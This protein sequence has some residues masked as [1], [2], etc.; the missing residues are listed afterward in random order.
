MLSSGCNNFFNYVW[1]EPNKYVCK[2]LGNFAKTIF[3]FI[4]AAFSEANVSHLCYKYLGSNRKEWRRN[5]SDF[6]IEKHRAVIEKSPSWHPNL[7]VLKCIGSELKND[8]GFWKRVLMINTKAASIISSSMWTEEFVLRLISDYES[9][10]RVSGITD[11]DPYSIGFREILY[12]IPKRLFDKEQIVLALANTRRYD[13]L[14]FM[15]DRLRSNKEFA[16]SVIQD[17]PF[18]I[19][20]FSDEIRDSDEITLLA[21]SKSQWSLLFA[22]PEK[23][24]QFLSRFPKFTPSRVSELRGPTK[25][26]FIRILDFLFYVSVNLFSRNNFRL[27]I[28]RVRIINT[29]AHWS[30]SS[31]I[32]AAG[33]ALL[34]RKDFWIEAILQDRV[35]LRNIPASIQCDR[36]VEL[37][38]GLLGDAMHFCE[39]PYRSA[40]DLNYGADALSVTL[41]HASTVPAGSMCDDPE[42][43]LFVMHNNPEIGVYLGPSLKKDV[44]FAR[45]VYKLDRCVLS[46]FAPEVQSAFLPKEPDE[47]F[48]L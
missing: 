3:D 5:D 17:H 24:E 32:F 45:K 42:L 47:G 37:I 34:E 46:C 30:Y 4:G 11:S 23:R 7:E 28:D 33:D 36:F 27:N 15:S 20:C 29:T 6:I 39:S 43:M 12:C 31:R 25:S 10:R 21:A 8:Y 19:K 48:S 2:P 13:L 26:R 35:L 9:F 22:S 41:H 38:S 18:S 1:N 14:N 44:D 40:Q 16:R